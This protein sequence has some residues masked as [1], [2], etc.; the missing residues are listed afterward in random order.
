QLASR[1]RTRSMRPHTIQSEMESSRPE[2]ARAPHAALAEALDRVGD[3]WTL[4]VIASLLD[5]PRRFGEIQET[6]PGIAPNV[7][8][9]RLRQLERDALVV[10]RAYSDRPPRFVYELST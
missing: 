6:L 1:Y 5:G 3:R 2:M 7:L 4:L 10:A 9:Q 8:T